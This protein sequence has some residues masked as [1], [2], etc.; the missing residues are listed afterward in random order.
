MSGPIKDT[1]LELAKFCSMDTLEIFGDFWQPWGQLETPGPSQTWFKNGLICENMQNICN[2][3][4][5]GGFYSLS[6][7][8]HFSFSLCF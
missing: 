6:K 5:L 8:A 1:L 7:L 4:P 2:F 3:F